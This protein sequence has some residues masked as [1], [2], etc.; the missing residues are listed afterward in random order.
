[1][2]VGMVALVD[3]TSANAA[4]AR[5]QARGV[6]AWV[7]GQVR[8]RHAGETGDAAAKGGGGGSASLVGDYA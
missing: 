2:G 8:D 3:P 5:L 4:L 1:M 6:P 7:A